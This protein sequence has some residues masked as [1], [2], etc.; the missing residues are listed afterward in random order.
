[1]YNINM[2][3]LLKTQANNTLNFLDISSFSSDNKDLI[4]NIWNKLSSPNNGIYTLS[5]DEEIKVN[6]AE[7]SLDS[8]KRLTMKD[9]FQEPQFAPFV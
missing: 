4:L 2:K 6:Q 7:K 5:K 8:G 1:M 3:T 9:V